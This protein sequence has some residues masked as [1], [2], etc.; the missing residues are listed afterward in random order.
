MSSVTFFKQISK[1][2]QETR[3]RY[4]IMPKIRVGPATLGVITLVII[5]L[6]SLLYLIQANSTATKGF[7]IEKEQEKINKLESQGEKLELEMAKL[8]S[9]KELETLPGK[10]NLRPLPEGE[11][12]SLQLETKEVLVGVNADSVGRNPKR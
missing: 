3:P 11:L 5:L 10:L 9:T 6:M 4:S 1:S 2:N 7:E 8:R 12:S